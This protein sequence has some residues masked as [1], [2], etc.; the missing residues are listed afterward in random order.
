VVEA[1]YVPAGATEDGELSVTLEPSLVPGCSQV[2][3]RWSTS[4]T[5]ATNRR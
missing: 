3:V 1:V 2:C 5:S 4:L